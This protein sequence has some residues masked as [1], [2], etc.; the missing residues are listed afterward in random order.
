M[1]RGKDPQGTDSGG[2]PGERTPA[3][4]P[5]IRTM[6]Y[7]CKVKEILPGFGF[8]RACL[9]IS[10]GLGLGLHAFGQQ[11]MTN[12]QGERILVFP[13]GSWRPVVPADSVYM[14]APEDPGNLPLPGPGQ[15]SETAEG[16]SDLLRQWRSLSTLINAREKSVQTRFRNATN[17]QFKAGQAWQYAKTNEVLLGPDQLAAFKTTY[18]AS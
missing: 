2:I 9:L 18:D 5:A 1:T 6:R 10:L 8:W 12:S 7:F 13:D 15:Q 4:H 17:A 3:A 14:R 16:R 11:V